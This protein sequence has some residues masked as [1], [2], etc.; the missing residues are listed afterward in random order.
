MLGALLNR[1]TITISVTGITAVL[2]IMFLIG[3]F[4]YPI[5]VL[6][7]VAIKCMAT[8]FDI[9]LIIV[10]LKL[11]RIPLFLAVSLSILGLILVLIWIL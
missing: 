5:E 3:Y 8:V 6:T 4:T 10:F 7:Q 2:V 9:I 1:V 11:C